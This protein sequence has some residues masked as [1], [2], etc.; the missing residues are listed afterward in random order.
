MMI[1]VMNRVDRNM[2]INDADLTIGRTLS[3][4]VPVPRTAASISTN[5]YQRTQTTTQNWTDAPSFSE[6]VL[7]N[8]LTFTV[9]PEYNESSILIRKPFS[10][11]S[12]ENIFFQS[13]QEVASTPSCVPK[14]NTK[15]SIAALR[16]RFSAQSRQI[17]VSGHGKDRKFIALPARLNLDTILNRI[18]QGINQS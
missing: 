16:A 11:E 3:C 2:M 6:D 13:P 7:N 8:N 1:P 15:I 4:P 9:Y 18:I 12:Y 14:K 17:L 10:F 5:L